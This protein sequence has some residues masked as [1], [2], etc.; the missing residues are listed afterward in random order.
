MFPAKFALAKRG[1]SP[2]PSELSTELLS[3]GEPT[4]KRRP[5]PIAAALAATAALLLTACGS[6]DDGSKAKDKIAGADNGDTKPSTSPSASGAIDRPKISLPSDLT[7]TFDS[8]KTGDATKDAILQDVAQRVDATNYAITQGDPDLPVLAFYYSGGALAD[9]KDWVESLAKD[10]YSITGV[11]RYYNAKVDVFDSAS[12][13][14]VYCEDQSKAFAKDR[15]SNKVYK[16]E[17]NDDSYVIYRTR[18]EK[19]TQGVWQTTTLTS[20][21]GNKSCMP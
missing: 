14:V 7:D 16:T 19:N 3:H 10:G 4:V 2:I 1:T 8:W 18:L 11:N 9:A 15:K 13:G 6:E 17:V 20:Q 5:L 21:R 12:A